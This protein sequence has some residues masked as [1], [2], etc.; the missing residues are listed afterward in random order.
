MP[1]LHRISPNGS[2]PLINYQLNES[3]IDSLA[4]QLKVLVPKMLRKLY[5]VN[6]ASTDSQ[7]KHLI[8]ELCKTKGLK[9]LVFMQNNFG[10]KTYKG[11]SQFLIPSIGFRSLKKFVVKD[12]IP[13]K[14]LPHEICSI[15]KQLHSNYFPNLSKLTLA[16][17][18]FNQ[19][20][21]IELANAVTR[22]PI[23]EHLDISANSIDAASLCQFF[24]IIAAGNQ[25]RSLN[26]AFNSLQQGT[27]FHLKLAKFLH[28]SENMILLDISGMGLKFKDYAH[29]A[30]RGLRKSKTLLSVHMQG[31]GLSDGDLIKLR[32]ALRVIKTL[33]PNKI[34]D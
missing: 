11:L 9:S 23:L 26:L 33:N 20:G 6:T 14:L 7:M 16:R 29:I 3:N 32:R 2:L 31:M 34:Q 17:V 10:E 8:V 30:E 12:P 27:D 4:H 5:L 24:D 18:G 25:L 21:V 13:N 1:I 19:E 22:Q 28:K 15:T